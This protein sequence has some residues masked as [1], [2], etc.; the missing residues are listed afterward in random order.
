MH[1]KQ[2]YWPMLSEF[3]IHINSKCGGALSLD[4]AKFHLVIKSLLFLK[5]T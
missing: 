5:M 4:L 1:T 2:N 3:R